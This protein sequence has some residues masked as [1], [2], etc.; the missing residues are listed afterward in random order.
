[1]KQLLEYGNIYKT[2]FGILFTVCMFLIGMSYNSVTD[3]LDKQEKKL[4]E[5]IELTKDLARHEIMLQ[6]NKEEIG[7]NRDRICD[8]EKD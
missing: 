6:V 4:D 8:L 5:I 7:E 2:L 1:M 3:R